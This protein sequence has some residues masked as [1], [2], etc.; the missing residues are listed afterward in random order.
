MIA[1]AKNIQQKPHRGD[2]T[3]IYN[4]RK[5]YLSHILR[6]KSKRNKDE[7]IIRGYSKSVKETTHPYFSNTT[8]EPC[9]MLQNE[10]YAPIKLFGK[11]KNSCSDSLFCRHGE[12]TPGLFLVNFDKCIISILFTRTAFYMI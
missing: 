9:C 5:Q 1:V 11:A 2:K 3:L 4:S 8:E 10:R 12:T 7:L 6:N